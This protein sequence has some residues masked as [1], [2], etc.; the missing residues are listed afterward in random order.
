MAADRYDVLIV[1]GGIMGSAT[2][3]NLVNLEPQLKVAVVERDFSYERASTTLSAANLRTVG[4]SLK[5]NYLISKQSFRILETFEDRMAV[6]GDRPHLYLRREGNL[7]LT[8]DAGLAEAQAIFDMHRQL[9]SDALWLQPEEIKERWPLFDVS[10]I[11]GGA[12]G[13]NDGHLDAH[14]MLTAYKRKAASLGATFIQEE[15]VDLLKG[16]GRVDGARLSSGEAIAAEK[17]VNCAGGWAA[18]VAGMAG[19]A[20][21]VSPVQRQVFVVDTKI[22]PERPLPFVFHPSGLWFRSETG[23]LLIL[24]RSMEEDRTGYDFKWDR[25]R[26]MNIL[27]PALAEFVPAFDTLKLIRGWTGLYEVNTLDSNAV[28]GPWPEIEGFYLCNGFSGHGMMQ[29]PAVGQY[30]AE[31]ITGRPTTMDLSVFSPER[32]VDHCPIGESGCY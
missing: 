10:G 25:D 7:L 15:V 24:G 30:L 13:P 3:Y 14:A 20:I 26:F 4:F 17:T 11:A 16:P 19:I 22:K 1:G 9:G 8:N 27:W 32:I 28:I 29:G 12:Y 6:D 2:A 23:G 5:E 21:P 31:I 18:D